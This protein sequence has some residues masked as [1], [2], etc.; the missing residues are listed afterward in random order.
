MASGAL[1][2]GLSRTIAIVRRLTDWAVILIFAFMVISVVL[3]VV[4]RY[5]NF[6]ISH[7]V[8]T[9]T[10]AQI[11][12]TTIGASAALRYGSMFALD[13]VTRYLKLG[14]ARAFSVLI[15]VLSIILVAVMFYGGVLMTQKGFDQLSPVLQMPMWPIFISLPIGMVLLCMEIVLQVVEKWS[16]P[17]PGNQEEVV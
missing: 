12:L 11:W 6:A 16:N 7:A 4:G 1:G 13:T 15:A 10:F 17:F 5:F 9:A 14:L 8:E 3:E 2:T